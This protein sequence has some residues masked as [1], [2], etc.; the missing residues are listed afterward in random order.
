MEHLEE[1]NRGFWKLKVISF[2]LPRSGFCSLD[3]LIFRDI[4]AV[5][6]TNTPIL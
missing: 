5:T 1:K 6:E 3:E 2:G 4:L